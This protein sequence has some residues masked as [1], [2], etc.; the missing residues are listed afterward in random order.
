M[1]AVMGRTACKRLPTRYG[2]SH[3]RLSVAMPVPL[4]S[5]QWHPALPTPAGHLF[6]SEGVEIR[7]TRNAVQVGPAIV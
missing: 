3:I 4:R 5:L 7:A 6:V 2:A 1:P